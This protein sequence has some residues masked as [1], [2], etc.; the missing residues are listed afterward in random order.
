MNLNSKFP[1]VLIAYGAFVMVAPHT[2]YAAPPTNACSLL[3]PAQVSSVLGAK[4]GAGQGL[5]G[6]MCKWSETGAPAKR[7]MLDLI[8]SQAFAAAKTPI[9]NGIVKT[10]V[11]GIGNDA[12]YV[13]ASGMPTTL[14]VK[15]GDAAFTIT[16][17]GFP[18]EKAKAM[19]KA[20]ALD[21]CSKL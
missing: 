18:D 8:N 13:S 4:V 14:T 2:T 11:S 5:M 6:K 1:L 15:K 12:V 20:L 9:G 7:V 10:D 3:T 17:A 19:E 16:V 21:I